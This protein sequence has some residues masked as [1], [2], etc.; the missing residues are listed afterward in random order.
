VTFVFCH[1]GR[2]L[3]WFPDADN[4]TFT[5]L[6]ANKTYTL[7]ER[8]VRVGEQPCRLNGKQFTGRFLMDTGIEVP[9]WEDYASRV[10]ELK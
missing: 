1:K 7:T 6:D 8:N 10:F 2:H 5:G 4:R 9:L 3:Y